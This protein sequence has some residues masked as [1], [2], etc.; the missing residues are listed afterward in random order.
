MFF[1]ASPFRVSAVIVLTLALGV[2]PSLRIFI[3]MKLIDLIADLLQSSA[4]IAF[5]KIFKLLAAWAVISLA[6]ELAV[7]LQGTLN[8][9]INEKFSASI[10]TGLS[11]KLAG[12]TDLSFFEKRENLVKIDMV[13]EQLQVRPQN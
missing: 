10:M 7:K 9:L 3:S 12:L 5:G 1:K 11:E 2:F 6:S 13:R 8:A 4:E